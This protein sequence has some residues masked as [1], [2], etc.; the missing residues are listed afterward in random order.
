[1]DRNKLYDVTTKYPY[2]LGGTKER[3]TLIAV[4]YDY[5]LLTNI[6]DMTTRHARLLS[7]DS[8]LPDLL[9]IPEFYVFRDMNRELV[10]LPDI[11]IS[12]TREI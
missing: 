3:L 9:D 4:V 10:V 6:C 11:Y 5:T 12:D 8:T 2:V 7:I 1:M